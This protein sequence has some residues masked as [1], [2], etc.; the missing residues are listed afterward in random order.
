MNNQKETHSNKERK[1]LME[2]FA[3]LKELVDTH[4]QIKGFSSR[5]DY[6]NDKNTK[7]N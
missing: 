5:E 3:F 2:E 1:T 7:T 6:L 4:Y